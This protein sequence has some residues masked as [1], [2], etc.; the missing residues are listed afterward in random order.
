MT[1]R[2]FRSAS[3]GA[4]VVALICL[5]PLMLLA[6]W[7]VRHESGEADYTMDSYVGTASRIRRNRHFP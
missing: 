4:P 2:T 5:T 1:Q 7:A 3:S 6:G